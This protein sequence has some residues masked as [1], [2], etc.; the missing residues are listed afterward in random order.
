MDQAHAEKLLNTVSQFPPSIYAV[1]DGDAVPQFGDRLAGFGLA[2]KPLYMNS[3]PR[4]DRAFGPH[5]IHVESLARMKQVLAL[6]EPD[7]TAVYWSWSGPMAAIEAHL[8]RL[9]SVDIEAEF[10]DP[11]RKSKDIRKVPVLF[12]HADPNVLEILLRVLRPDQ[13][14]AFFGGSNGICY[15][16]R[17]SGDVTAWRN[18]PAR[19]KPPATHRRLCLTHQQAQ[20]PVLFDRQQLIDEIESTL[21]ET[22]RQAVGAFP[23]GLVKSIINETVKMCFVWHI[24]QVENLTF[25][26]LLR[27]EIS[28]GYFRQGTINQILM[29]RSLSE[30]EKMLRLTD[31]SLEPAWQQ[32]ENFRGPQEWMTAADT[33][34]P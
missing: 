5:L 14:A 16:S 15:F 32:A 3:G 27:W 2:G 12:R 22:N 11:D 9:N 13:K 20:A 34:T 1:V 30:D 10:L 8:R 25:L 33:L 18:D 31:D 28:P 23:P 7:G 6:S 17:K 29:D 24:Y 4:H 19:H 21:R 26:T